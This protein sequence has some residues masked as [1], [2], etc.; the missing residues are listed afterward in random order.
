[1]YDSTKKLERIHAAEHSLYS[2]YM[3]YF[4]FA[5]VF[6]AKKNQQSSYSIL[7]AYSMFYF[8]LV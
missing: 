4:Y 3:Q 5:S 8:V 1:M 7:S 6:E 2:V